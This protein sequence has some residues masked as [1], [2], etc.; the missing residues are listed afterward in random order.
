MTWEA[1]QQLL[2][3]VGGKLEQNAKSEDRH[4]LVAGQQPSR[5]RDSI[6]DRHIPC[7]PIVQCAKLDAESHSQYLRTALDA[8]GFHRSA[9]A[10]RP[11]HYGRDIPGGLQFA[12]LRRREIW[13]AG[14]GQ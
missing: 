4:G 9:V 3:R 11:H 10:L 1:H 2:S 13:Q 6:S 7:S 14:V 8:S 12:G 5:V